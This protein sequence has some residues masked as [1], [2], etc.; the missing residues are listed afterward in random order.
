[1]RLFGSFK[2]TDHVR[3]GAATGGERKSKSGGKS[4]AGV[5]CLAILLVFV[6]I[7]IPMALI[8]SCV[9]KIKGE[10]PTTTAV[11][12]NVEIQH[13]FDSVDIIMNV[14]DEKQESFYVRYDGNVSVDDF[15]VVSANPA[16]A[17][18]KINKDRSTSHSLYV[19]IEAVSVGVVEFI[20]KTT[21][22]KYESEPVTVTVEPEETTTE[23][24]TTEKPTERQTVKPTQKA[25]PKP[26]GRTVYV[27]PNGEKY[28]LDPDCGGENSYA[29]PFDQ[30]G[31]RTPCQKCAQ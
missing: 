30:I 8:K 7:A 6:V 18:S 25:E 12:S 5:G 14:G 13:N 19:T 29:I 24:L 11:Y 26:E 3:I 23:E 20:V 27:T 10:E 21:D 1:M 2:L 15:A 31:G 16:I 17:T 22:G 4:S 28:H 9:A